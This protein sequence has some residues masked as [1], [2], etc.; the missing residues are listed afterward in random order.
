MQQ[1]RSPF[2]AWYATSNCTGQAYTT[3]ET[4]PGERVD[5]MPL[6]TTIGVSTTTGTA[7]YQRT[8]SA[9]YQGISSRYNGAGCWPYSG[10]PSVVPIAPA[11]TMPAPLPAPLTLRMQ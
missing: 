11:T 5:L 1:C 8:G 7:V 4:S 10:T 6:E 9:R 3:A 2:E